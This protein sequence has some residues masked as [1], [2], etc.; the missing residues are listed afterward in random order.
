MAA[1]T[2]DNPDVSIEKPRPTL[3]EL[4][5]RKRKSRQPVGGCRETI[6]VSMGPQHPSTH[7]VFRAELDLDG[8]I[9][10]NARPEIGNLHRGVE[11]LAEYR[12]YHQF[13]PVTDRLDYISSFAMN[14]AYCEAVEK[15]M[16][17]EVPPRARYIRTLAHELTRIA[18]HLL[19]LGVHVMDL[20]AQTFFLITFRDREYILDLFEMLRRWFRTLCTYFTDPVSRRVKS[21]ERWKS[22]KGRWVFISLQTEALSLS[23]YTWL[24]PRSIIAKLSPRCSRVRHLRIRWASSVV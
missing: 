19:W 23:G 10:V 15:L 1:S 12:T 22:R 18:N 13:I 3:E 14:H 4:K 9:I 21:I 2:H 11:K 16:G 6:T 7:G 20:G 24:P 17:V 8:E 5:E